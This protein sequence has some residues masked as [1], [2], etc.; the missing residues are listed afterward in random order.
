MKKFRKV[1]SIL[2]AALLL[3]SCFGAVVAVADIVNPDEPI[4]EWPYGHYPQIYVQGFESKWIYY[5]DDPAHKSLLFPVDTDRLLGNFMNYSKYAGEALEKNDP[6][7]VYNIVYGALW[8]SFGATA[9]KPDG[10]TMQDNVTVDPTYLQ[11]DYVDGEYTFKYDARLDPVDVAKELRTYVEWVKA[12]SR[13]DKIELVG[14]SY[15]TSVVVAYIAEYGYDDIDSVVLCVPSLEGVNFVGELFSGSFNFDPDAVEAFAGG[16][17]PDENIKLLLSI[18]N[19]LGFLDILLGFLVEPVLNLAVMN[20]LEDIIH[21]IFAT[22]PAMWAFVEEE[23]FYEA[24]E[25]VYGDDWNEDTEEYRELIDKV[26]YFH[27]NI[28]VRDREIIQNAVDGG[29]HFN[30]IAKYNKAPFPFSEDGNFTGDG[31]VDLENAS[32]GA[33]VA[34]NGETLPDDYTQAKLTEYDFISPDRV[35]DASTC[36]LPFNTWFIKD[37]AHGE[38]PEYYYD[39]INRIL[40]E[41]LDV[42]TSD[43]LPQFI[44]NTGDAIVPLEEEEKEPEL[45]LL[46]KLTTFIRNIFNMLIEAIKGL[47]A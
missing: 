5:K 23:Y 15:G 39:V 9:L 29:L 8:D 30:V 16:M 42:F 36:H 46:K 33:T 7:L 31:F 18:M 28:K 38:K 45:S 2:L 34:M 44:K 24:L 40:Y 22:H 43:T 37:L 20:A 47:F 35:I 11:F 14:S 13:Q 26:I 3:S 41:D 21:D 32:L 6:R 1:I 4:P 25:N 19:D 27:E 17:I 12:H 10:I